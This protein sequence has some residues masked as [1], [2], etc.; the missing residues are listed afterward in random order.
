MKLSWSACVRIGV[1]ATLVLLIVLCREQLWAA[2]RLLSGA[3]APL[4]LGAAMAYAVN[5]LMSFYERHIAPKGRA[6][7]WREKLRRPVCMALAFLTVVLAIYLLFALILPQLISCFQVLLAALPKA[8]HEL[9]GWLDR[10]F[11]LSAVLVEADVAIPATAA[12]WKAL[13]E[14]VGRP[15]LTGVTGVMNAAVSVTSTVAGGVVSFLMA[16]IFAVHLLL[17]KERLEGQLRRLMSRVLGAR[18]ERCGHVLEVLNDC[19]HSYIVGQCVEALIL[20]A[21]CAIGMLLLR[22]PYALMIGALV[23][24]LALIPI[25]GAYIGAAVGA[26]MIFSVSPMQ[27][28][29]FLIFLVILQQ[30]EGNLIYPHTVGSSLGLPGIWVLAAVVIGGGT[31][32]ITGMLFAVPL[33]AALYRLMREWLRKTPQEKTRL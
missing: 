6:R 29:V 15:L 17:S 26:V 8:W 18:M 10:H 20:G 23:G 5:I 32:G 1:T 11:D 13:A 31:A 14:K 9:Y 7:L 21:L 2:V 3:V 28:L 25:A 24:V 12:E 27:A 22:L 33:T 4:A 16:L 19:F 30:I